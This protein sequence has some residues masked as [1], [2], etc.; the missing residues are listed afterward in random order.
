ML[1]LGRLV[2]GDDD[3]YIVFWSLKACLDPEC[4]LLPRQVADVATQRVLD[5]LSHFAIKLPQRFRCD[6]VAMHP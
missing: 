3:G 6:D 4:G 2:T 1:L 5:A